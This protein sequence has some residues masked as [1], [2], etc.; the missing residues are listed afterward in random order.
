LSKK[1]FLIK[2]KGKKGMKKAVLFL[3]SICALSSAQAKEL[4]SG[5]VMA[6]DLNIPGLGWAGHV[7]MATG[8]NIGQV[9]PYVIEALNEDPMPVIQL[10]TQ[11][12][13]KLRSPY[14]GSRW[15]IGEYGNR[16]RTALVEFNHQR[17]WCPTYTMTSGYIVGV[18]NPKNGEIRVCGQWRCDTALAWSFFYAG[19][20]ELLDPFFITPRFVFNRFP[21][22]NSNIAS[23]Q[24]HQ[25]DQL[26]PLGK[27]FESLTA[28]ELNELDY[29]EFFM[30]ADTPLPNTTPTHIEAEWKFANNP[31][32]VPVKRGMFID[33]LGM[34]KGDGKV[35]KFIDL[36]NK[37]TDQQV[38]NKALQALMIHYQNY[39]EQVEK[40]DEFLMLKEFYTKLIQKDTD[41]YNTEKILRGFIDFSSEEELF[42]STKLI[43]DKSALVEQHMLLGLRNNLMLKSARME[44]IYFPKMLEMVNGHNSDI[45][46]MFFGIMKFSYP[47]LKE[48]KHVDSLRKYVADVSAKYADNA[49]ANDGFASFAQ[50]SLDELR[51]V[52]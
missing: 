25:D 43:E 5:D 34:M 46:D 36:Y 9:S 2:K 7:G 13:F 44:N 11:K 40:T 15:G 1:Q 31:E 27:P 23:N 17:W 41:R 18:G 26:K 16:T 42:A 38:K 39:R 52:L 12:Y 22:A 37:E 10:N 6:R 3:T 4:V 35:K 30:I 45:N 49:I 32:V 24:A 20:P 8:D 21:F 48:Q 29:R 51:S 14:W 28:Q 33:R 19:M 50:E 47:H